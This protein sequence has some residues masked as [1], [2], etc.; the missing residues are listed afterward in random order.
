MLI[1]TGTGLTVHTHLKM[2]G[3]WRARA[4]GNPA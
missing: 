3:S 2:D 4:T 1:R